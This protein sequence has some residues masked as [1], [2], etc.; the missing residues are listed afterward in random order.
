MI[1][2]RFLERRGLTC[3]IDSQEGDH[4]TCDV[5]KL[6]RRVAKDRKRSRNG[7][8]DGLRNAEDQADDSDKNELVAG[9]ASLHSLILE[10]LVMLQRATMHISR[11]TIR[12]RL[13]KLKL[14]RLLHG[15]ITV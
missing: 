2:E 9:P 6:V 15:R 3:Q 7:S 10:M 14:G 4:E 11:V 5:A 13:L 1:A 8:S 12:H